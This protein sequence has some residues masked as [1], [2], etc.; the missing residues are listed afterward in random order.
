MSG[1]EIE[2][3]SNLNLIQILNL[4]NKN[5]IYYL[6]TNFPYFSSEQYI[7]IKP[8]ET[9]PGGY[10]LNIPP[11]YKKIQTLC[12][13]LEPVSYFTDRCALHIHYDKTNIDI[14]STKLMYALYEQE[15]VQDA[16]DHD[17]YVN[18]NKSILDENSKQK[19]RNLRLFTRHNTIEHRIYKATF[20]YDLIQWCIHQLDKII[21]Y[22]N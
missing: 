8:D 14:N 10:E 6:Y 19:Y 21:I 3:F 7:V 5:H 17:V 13:I 1:I 20:D 18:L 4:F 15:I 12:E 2:F 11:T 22:N 16:K 9:I